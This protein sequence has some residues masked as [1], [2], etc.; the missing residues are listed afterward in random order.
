MAYINPIAILKQTETLAAVI[1]S[2][3]TLKETEPEVFV[4]VAGEIKKAIIVLEPNVASVAGAVL[5]RYWQ[6]GDNP[7]LTEGMP[8][9]AFEKVEI[10]SYTDVLNTR[11]L[12]VD[13]LEHKLQ[14]QLF[15]Y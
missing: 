9:R 5:A 1:K 14:I 3:S 7:T 10:N 15:N 11:L 13:G 6:T 8:I 2:I 12:A 4:N